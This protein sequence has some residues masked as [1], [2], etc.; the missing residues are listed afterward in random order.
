VPGDFSSVGTL[1]LSLFKGLALAISI[2]LVVYCFVRSIGC[3]IDGLRT[4]LRRPFFLVILERLRREAENALTKMGPRTMTASPPDIEIRKEIVDPSLV[5]KERNRAESRAVAFLVSLNGIAAIAIL[6]SLTQGT[7]LAGNVMR[8]ADAMMVFGS[9]AA[10]GLASALFAYLRR[11]LDTEIPLAR[12]WRRRLPWLAMTAAI[13]GTICFIVGL[14]MAR[15]AVQEAR[16][17]RHPRSASLGLS[18]SRLQYINEFY[19]AKV[20][21]G[22]IAGIVI[23]IARHGKLAH[24]SA[25]GYSDIEKKR[26]MMPDTIFRAYSMTKPIAAVALMM[27]YEEGYFQLDD[28]ISKY[29][30][31]FANPRVLRSPNSSLA[32]T[33]PAER[34][35][36][37]HDLLR[38][39]AG[40]GHGLGTDAAD[41]EYLNQ[42][43]FGVDVSLAEMTAKL[44]K[45]P[46]LSQPGTVF[47]Y[48]VAPDVEAR[49][50]E[51]FSGMP[52][53]R[54][55]EERLFKPLRM[56]DAGFWLTPDRSARLA[57]LYW[58]NNGKLTPLDEAHGYPKG[59]GFLAEPWSVNSYT[60]DHSRKGGSYGMLT[61]AQDYWHFGQ[62]LLDRGVFE[63]KRLLSPH[64]V[65]FMTRNHLDAKQREGLGKGLGW[66]LGFAV[67]EDPAGAGFMSS[68]G[69]FY[70]AGAANTHFWIDPKEDMVVVALAQDMANPGDASLWPQIRTLVYSA[71]TD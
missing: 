67:M 8:F 45:I 9:G 12:S 60:L 5:E 29:I 66:G 70:W 57:T 3:V 42:N 41:A 59:Q 40:L 44:A 6:I 56:N 51:I 48:S 16:P 14:N 35:P 15:I 20:K 36:T 58:S 30:P 61:T 68:E 4:S 38:H 10:A 21:R 22:E 37:I 11:S 63:G 55:L 49:L 26:K 69:T 34:E 23:L 39:T 25:I 54:F 53:D 13:V 1:A 62:M 43:L 31:E 32:D 28:P 47:I 65:E 50:V 2:S 46:L 24:L 52:F 7:F 18:A 27:L 71:L 19:A 33:V 17:Q 64:V